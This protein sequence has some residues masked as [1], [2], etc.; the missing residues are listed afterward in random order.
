MMRIEFGDGTTATANLI[1]G[2][3]GIHSSIRSQFTPDDYTYSGRVAYR[4]LVPIEDIKAWWPLQSYSA[5]WL[6]KDR[7]LLVF[8]ISRNKTMNIVAFVTKL[9][10]EVS[11]MRESWTATGQRA[12]LE[13]DF[14]GF[15]E[16]IQRV[17]ACMPPQPSKWLLNDREPLEQWVF[18][19]G[20][21]LLMGDAAHAML[22][23][24]GTFNFRRDCDRKL[25]CLQA[26]ER[27]KLLKMVISLEERRMIFLPLLLRLA[28]EASNS[29]PAYISPSGYHERKRHK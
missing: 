23:H 20:K 24:Q 10:E 19:H 21:V 28:N 9:E 3:D 13:K 4:G 25:I 1:V 6:C 11:G 12:E 14:E 26:L 16:T 22:P 8:P 17:I 5:S 15:E 18:C 29:G 7:H 27:V 2:C